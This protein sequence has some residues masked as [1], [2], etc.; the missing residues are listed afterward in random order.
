[1]EQIEQNIV[2]FY[3]TEKQDEALDY[4]NDNQ[5]E[6]IL[7]GG[8]ISG[9]KSVLGCFWIISSCLKYP[10]SR[11]LIGR[12]V[13]KDLKQSTIQTLFIML[14]EV[15]HFTRDIEYNYNE[16]S[17]IFKFYNGSEIIL[18]DMFQNPSDPE[19]S[20][21]GSLEITSAFLDEVQELTKKARDVLMTRIRFKLDKF[22][23]IPKLLLC[24][25]PTKNFLFDDFYEPWESGKLPKDKMFVQ[26]LVYSNPY[27]PKSYLKVLERQ[28]GTQKARLLRGDWNYSE[29]EECLFEFSK[30]KDM[31]NIPKQGDQEQYLS[32]DP[33]GEGENMT[34]IV[35]WNG[36]FIER[37][38]LYPKSKANEIKDKINEIRIRD[39]I[40]A[41]N[42]V[43]DC[44]GAGKPIYDFL[45]EE[46]INIQSFI[47]NSSPIRKRVISSGIYTKVP[48]QNY[49]NLKAQCYHKL[50]QFV[51]EGKVGVYKEI[52]DEYKKMLIRD[53]TLCQRK[54]ISKD[55][56]F[57]LVGK[58][59]VT[60]RL[61]RSPDTGDACMFRMIFEIRPPLKVY[62]AGK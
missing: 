23:L 53:L 62:W 24:A 57:Q 20:S 21:L 46:G 34:A 55:G 41:R 44:D 33:A 3:P 32:I 29:E 30:I 16:Q 56:K 47:N 54:D 37:I 17:G 28:E 39:G 48:E 43:M 42:I 51:N 27:V 4:L 18:K 14:N 26:A 22:G 58:D 61:S 7:F 49:A 35:K 1:M 15:F 5:T 9:G 36:F 40:P 10:E 38:R 13:L 60:E 52:P 19:F 45:K 59:I 6:Q 50:A 11:H 25:N 2:D 31:F 8:G 12:A